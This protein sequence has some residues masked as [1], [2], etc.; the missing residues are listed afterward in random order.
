MINLKFVGNKEGLLDYLD[1]EVE[2]L[3]MERAGD[4]EDLQNDNYY[5]R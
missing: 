5:D 2:K 1:N 3:E 4:L